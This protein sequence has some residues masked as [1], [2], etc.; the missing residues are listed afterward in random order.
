VC[1][2]K[3]CVVAGTD[4]NYED[5]KVGN[6]SEDSC[7]TEFWQCF[8]ILCCYILKLS[9]KI[10]CQRSWENPRREANVSNNDRLRVTPPAEVCTIICLLVGGLM[11]HRLKISPPKWVLTSRCC[12]I[13]VKPTPVDVAS[14][15]DTGWDRWHL[16]TKS[17][18][19]HLF[20]R[21]KRFRRF[22]RRTYGHW[23][24]GTGSATQIVEEAT[25]LNLAKSQD[26]RSEGNKGK[27]RSDGDDGV[28]GENWGGGRF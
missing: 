22:E 13:C 19:Q 18:L 1:C 2:V 26:T 24:W 6:G 23:C 16:F 7:G 8:Y 14:A 28:S 21:K 15:P 20:E 3:V 17:F 9:K 27:K 4:A 12:V 5:P 10:W 11:A 25:P